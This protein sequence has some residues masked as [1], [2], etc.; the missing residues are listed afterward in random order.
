MSLPRARGR[1]SSCL[2]EG[3]WPTRCAP[4]K[5]RSASATALR[6][7]W[8][9]LPWTSSPGRLPAYARASRSA[10][11]RRPCAKR[12]AQGH[13]AV[14]APY[15]LVADRSDIP[16]S[17][18]VTSDSLALWLGRRLGAERC[19]VVKSIERSA[20]T[21]APSSSPATA[22]SMKPSRPCSGRRAFPSSSSA[23]AIRRRF[24]ASLSAPRRHRLRRN[25]RLR[26]ELAP[27]SLARDSRLHELLQNQPACPSRTERPTS[28]STFR[29][30]LAP[31]RD[32]PG[33]PARRF[34][35]RGIA[36]LEALRSRQLQIAA[37]RHA[38]QFAPS[39]RL[40]GA[41]V[42]R[43]KPL[44]SCGRGLARRRARRRAHG[45]TASSGSLSSFD[46]RFSGDYP[47]AR[48][49]R[50]ALPQ[51][52]SGNVVRDARQTCVILSATGMPSGFCSLPYRCRQGSRRAERHGP[53][54][55]TRPLPD[56]RAPSGAPRSGVYAM[57]GRAFRFRSAV[58]VRS[59]SADQAPLSAFGLL[60]RESNLSQL[61]A[62]TR[63][64]PGR[65]PG[66]AR[67]PNA[68][69]ARGRR[70]LVQ[71]RRNA[72]RSDP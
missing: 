66:I 30:R 58:K 52:E 16:Q 32:R 6:I 1:S 22:W 67:V 35:G 38:A 48:A 62:G 65:S 5:R 59:G 20:P 45:G 31:L 19:Y 53:S 11:P 42:S 72:S 34:A 24:A 63:S 61:L 10:T 47:S 14:W 70:N 13:V 36:T 33:A 7:A 2:E 21:S 37:A 69:S 27:A 23:A 44:A 46:V 17:W 49:S 9:C 71:L 60:E 57:P 50:S 28:P 40:L 15:S 25:H 29:S 64:G 68:Y 51:G 8:R 39:A 56:V 12:L 41:C 55:A 26:R 54:M 4:R 43:S 3:P 18:T